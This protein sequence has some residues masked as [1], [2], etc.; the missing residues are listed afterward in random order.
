MIQFKISV[1]HKLQQDQRV[2]NLYLSVDEMEVIKENLK[3]SY[4]VYQKA[5]AILAL[6][7]ILPMREGANEN[8]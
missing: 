3:S 5:N 6:M 7:N 8:Y 1:F 4:N 2:F